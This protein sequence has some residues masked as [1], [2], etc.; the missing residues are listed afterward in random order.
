MRRTYSE[1]LRS[2]AGLVV[3]HRRRAQD[4][5]GKNKR[6]DEGAVCVERL[7]WIG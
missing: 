4:D 6:E 3:V 7:G 2:V 1:V 5:G